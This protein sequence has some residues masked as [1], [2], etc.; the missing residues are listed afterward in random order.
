M[1]SAFADGG[2]VAG[3]PWSV[4]KSIVNTSQFSSPT[5]P[6]PDICS[7]SLD[8][9]LE[10]STDPSATARS[11]GHPESSGTVV[12]TEVE[13]VVVDAAVVAVVVD[14]AAFP[15]QAETTITRATEASS[16]ILRFLIAS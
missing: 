6:S 1:N 3:A 4:A 11:P 13:V 16:E 9:S 5:H 12:T 8:G 14:V 10:T 2:V 15:P 7:E